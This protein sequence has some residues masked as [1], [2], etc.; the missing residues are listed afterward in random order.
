MTISKQEEKWKDDGI[1]KPEGAAGDR[2]AARGIGFRF[3]G[4]EDA[5]RI[6]RFLDEEFIPD[7]PLAR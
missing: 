6:F 4:A 7:E 5:G 2:L 3:A 1:L